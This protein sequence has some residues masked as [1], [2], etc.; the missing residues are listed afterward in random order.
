MFAAYER[1]YAPRSKTAILHQKIFYGLYVRQGLNRTEPPKLLK[2]RFMLEG[3]ALKFERHHFLFEIFN[4]KLQQ[5]LEA[6]LVQFSVRKMEE[7][8]N[9]KRYEVYKEPFSVLTLRELEAGFV[10]CLVPL[11]LGVL[12]FA[13]EWMPTLKDL[14]VFKVIFEN[15][16]DVKN[17]EQSNYS[18]S[19]RHKIANWQ[20]DLRE[21]NQNCKVVIE[22][23]F[24]KH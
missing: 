14:V 9:P 7:Y 20:A 3:R 11:I 12:V 10:V 23:S 21:S 2:D 8:I 5:Y 13:I 15:Y 6:D 4:R 19:M 1:A 18:R 16:F 22:S 24:A 17:I